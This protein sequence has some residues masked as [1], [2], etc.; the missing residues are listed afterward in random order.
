MLPGLL[1]AHPPRPLVARPCLG[2]RLATA[3]LPLGLALDATLRRNE[4]YAALGT[5]LAP[6]PYKTTVRHLTHPY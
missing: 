3:A 5:I 4:R 2:R 1:P 6:A